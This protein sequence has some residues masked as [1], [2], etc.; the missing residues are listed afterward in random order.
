MIVRNFRV[1]KSIRPVRLSGFLLLLALPLAA[2]TQGA[3]KQATTTSSDVSTASPDSLTPLAGTSVGAQSA[4]AGLGNVMTKGGVFTDAKGVRWQAQILR[5]YVAA[6][7]RT[8]HSVRFVGADM[9]TSAAPLANRVVCEEA[10]RWTIVP[11]LRNEPGGPVLDV[12]GP[13]RVSQAP[14]TRSADKPAG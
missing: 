13:A 11:P 7:W 10:G 12:A 2:C 1:L 3:T 9:A 14:S 8:C 6:S 5:S 4:A